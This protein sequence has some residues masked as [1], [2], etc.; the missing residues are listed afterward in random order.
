MVGHRLSPYTRKLVHPDGCRYLDIID[1]AAVY[2]NVAVNR[3]HSQLRRVQFHRNRNGRFDESAAFGFAVIYSRRCQI[4]ANFIPELQVMLLLGHDKDT[5]SQQNRRHKA[6]QILLNPPP[7]SAAARSSRSRIQ[8]KILQPPQNRDDRPPF[9]QQKHIVRSQQ[10]IPEQK[11]SY[12]N[13]HD[14]RRI[15]PNPKPR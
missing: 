15:A 5:G 3:V 11:R 10:P 9:Q 8:D 14:R 12:A 4:Q 2:Q 1:R 6:S 13:Q 7:A